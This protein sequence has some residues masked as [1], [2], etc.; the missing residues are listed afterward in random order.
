MVTVFL[1]MVKKV[2]IFMIISQTLLHL[3]I[4]R[5]Y[6]KYIRLAISFMIAAQMIF[7]FAAFS[8]I[9]NKVEYQKGN[10]ME[11]WEEEMQGFEN[12]MEEVQE[13]FY[14]KLKSQV[15][16]NSKVIEEHNEAKEIHVETIKIE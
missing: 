13:K 7:S 10:F 4:A 15:A 9:Q 11:E 16:E 3:G 5:K 8:K 12:N 14:E 6:E 2:G 1:E